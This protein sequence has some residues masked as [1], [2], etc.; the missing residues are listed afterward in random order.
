MPINY[1]LTGEELAY[2]V[3]QS[4]SRVL[5]VDPTLAANLEA[6]TQRPGQVVPLR[7]APGSLLEAA[8]TGEVPEID[9][10]SPT[11][12]WP[13][14]STPAAPRRGPRAR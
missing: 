14:C 3:E 4:G 6:L 9:V 1:A 2:L 10:T 5:I 11:P 8:R 7:D 12:T 13:S